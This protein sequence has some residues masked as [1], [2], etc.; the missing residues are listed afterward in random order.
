MLSVA[1][2]LPSWSLNILI[3]LPNRKREKKLAML[4]QQELS[5]L[6]SKHNKQVLQI[7][8]TRA[9]LSKRPP[10]LEAYKRWGPDNPIQKLSKSFPSRQFEESQFKHQ[11][12]LEA[13][14][15]QMSELNTLLNSAEQR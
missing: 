14:R 9:P 5:G 4:H 7:A 13:L 8:L 6:A 15:L 1:E 3:Y 11:N 12:E 10:F 2:R